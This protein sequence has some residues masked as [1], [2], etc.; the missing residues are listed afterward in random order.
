M[1]TRLTTLAVGLSTLTAISVLP[2]IPVYASSQAPGITMPQPQS[3]ASKQ[4]RAHYARFP[5]PATT[6][7]FHT[8]LTRIR[9]L[10]TTAANPSHRSEIT[11]ILDDPLPPGLDSGMY[12]LRCACE[13]ASEKL[14]KPLSRG[15]LRVGARV[16]QFQTRQRAH[17]TSVVETYLPQDF[18]RSI[19]Y[20]VR[21][22]SERADAD[23]VREL[24]ETG[25]TVKE[26]YR[27]LWQ[28]Q[29]RRREAL[30]SIGN[31]SG[32][33]KWLVRFLAGVPQPLLTFAREIN[34][35][36]GPT[37]ALRAKFGG[38]LGELVGFAVEVNALL[39]AVGDDGVCHVE[40]AHVE[41]VLEEGLT[42]YD[43]EVERFVELLEEVII[44]SPFFAAE[45]AVAE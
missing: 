19:F 38:V 33:W 15:F 44:N 10:R 9:H 41:K 13:E 43:R 2:T 7:A 16:E 31:A 23:A 4:L 1:R 3:Q 17:V 40:D 30:S 25:G 36:N 28:Q 21:A 27:L 45:E 34:A 18:R 32:I 29:W 20:S 26:K 35:P 6:Q 22:R 42:V 12:K 37:E 8:S 24:V 14:P 5:D 39:V 11:Q